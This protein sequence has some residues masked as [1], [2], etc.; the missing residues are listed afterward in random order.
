M[1][2]NLV[3]AL[4]LGFGF[5]VTTA[6]NSSTAD[7]GVEVTKN[8]AFKNLK[9]LSKDITEDQLK[10]VMY[11]FNE[12]LGVKCN[13]CHVETNDGKLNFASDANMHK[14]AARDMMKMTMKINKKY[15]KVTNPMEYSV[16]CNTC[17][18]GQV[19]PSKGGKH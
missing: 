13:F 9:V 1:K 8:P 3:F 5:A 2:K 19:T 12:A 4:V 10:G 7:K 14:I 16:N 15:F 6:F 17:H 18:N 11:S